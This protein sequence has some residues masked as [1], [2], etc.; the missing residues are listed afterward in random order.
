[1][2]LLRSRP[3][4]KN[5][6]KL[7]DKSAEREEDQGKVHASAKSNEPKQ[8]PHKQSLSSAVSEAI[9]SEATNSAQLQI[10]QLHD[11]ISNLQKQLEEATSHNKAIKN[12]QTMVTLQ[13]QATL[14]NRT[15]QLEELK[16]DS[17]AR[18][19]K[20]MNV[21][22][23]LVREE[24]L[25]KAQEL[26]QKLA[27]DG[28][29]LGRLVASRVHGGMR[30]H[31]IESWEDGNEPK[32]LKS[33]RGEL[34]K[35]R[36]R[37]EKRWAELNLMEMNHVA[38]KDNAALTLADGEVSNAHDDR[39]MDDLERFEA[40]ET[41]RMHLEEV[42]REERKL[43]EEERTLN[44]EKRAHVRTLKLVANEDASKFRPRHKVRLPMR[45]FCLYVSDTVLSLFRRI[46][47][48]AASRSLRPTKH[49]GQRWFQ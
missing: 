48:L 38:V 10:A 25:R 12:N 3:K 2:F 13:L 42:K 20:A 32:L 37:L 44:L 33:R 24:S 36:D 31:P 7:Q 45:L 5:G 40:R 41:I 11:K 8:T 16:Q 17:N 29:R 18:M 19:T 43:D 6:V 39:P 26:R 21:I 22:E 30:S 27:S 15:A 4:N 28:A 34:R 9:H 23:H 47:F 35:K 14:K 46:V 1:M 49:L